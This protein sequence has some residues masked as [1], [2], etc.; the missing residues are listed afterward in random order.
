MTIFKK[1]I[2]IQIIRLSVIALIII[3]IVAFKMITS[4]MINAKIDKI[5]GNAKGS[6]SY[7]DT[8]MD[9]FGFDVHIHD[10]KL[11]IPNQKPLLVD[12]MIV[13]SLDTENAVPRYMNIKLKGVQSDLAMLRSNPALAA[14]LD[15]LNLKDVNSNLIINYAFD[16]DQK[17]IDVKELT[18]KVQDA[19]MISYKTKLYNIVAMEYFPMQ[20]NLAPQTIKFGDTSLHYEDNSFMEHW[21][22]MK[23][24]DANQS[25]AIY[26]DERLKKMQTDLNTAKT[27]SQSYEA[28]LD[29]AL[30]TFI[31]DPKSFDFAIAPK[32][33]VSLMT[34]GPIQSRDDVLK[35][36]NLKVSAND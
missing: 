9:L 26:K 25:V 11:N 21:T 8:S 6:I 29:E 12:E 16:K 14:K 13:K 2:P 7:G 23:A 15:I 33:P 32:E 4:N 30:I 24:Q 20:I 17:M 36:L 34:L 1:E 28:L 27:N 19:G 5:L 22:N 35:T 3:A 31:K 10:I 18:L